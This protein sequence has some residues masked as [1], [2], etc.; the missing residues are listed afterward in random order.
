M[1]ET[2]Y[3]LT[4]LLLCTVVILGIIT[5]IHRKLFLLLT[6][7]CKGESRASFWAYAIEVWFFLYSLSSALRW[8]PD[9][10]SAREL[11]FTTIKQIKDGLSGMSTALI[12]FSAG[13]LAFVLIRTLASPGKSDLSKEEIHD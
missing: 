3:F 7:L 9:G 8:C 13:L 2:G 4:G 1:T 10:T 6:D 5:I 12:M 11:F